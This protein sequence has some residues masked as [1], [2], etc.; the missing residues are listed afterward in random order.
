MSA[1]L[2]GDSRQRRR[3]V[4]GRTLLILIPI[5]FALLN[6]P[7]GS[8]H[9]V[10]KPLV[11]TIDT[12]IAVSV[13]TD[14]PSIDCDT[15]MYKARQKAIQTIKAQAAN[16]TCPAECPNLTEL[17]P[18]QFT[19]GPECQAVLINGLTRYYGSAEAQETWRC[20]TF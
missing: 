16:I 19:C 6:P 3:R 5:T 14:A 4:R 11:C 8:T 12:T 13:A 1:L 18:V 15:A 7:P 20:T 10:A 9:A 2:N 17:P